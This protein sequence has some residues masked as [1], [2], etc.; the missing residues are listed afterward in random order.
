MQNAALS[1]G[2]T[3]S[4]AQQTPIINSYQQAMLNEFKFKC[5]DS[6]YREHGQVR[7]NGGNKLRNY[8]Q[9]ITE[10]T[11]EPVRQVF[12]DKSSTT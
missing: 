11:V 9:F 1:H 7:A 10:F 8:R 12:Y 2:H 5:E 6:V 4:K 3:Y